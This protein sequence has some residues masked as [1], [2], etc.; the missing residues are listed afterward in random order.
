M[1]FLKL[2]VRWDNPHWALLTERRRVGHTGAPMRCVSGLN[3]YEAPG[4]QFWMGSEYMTN[5][6]GR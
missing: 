5:L 1:L 3:C 2:L 4:W 6:Y